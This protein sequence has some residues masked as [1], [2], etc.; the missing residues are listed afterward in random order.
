VKGARTATASVLIAPRRVETVSR[1][2]P[3]AGPRDVV[4][5][6]EGCGVC[7]S[8]LPLWEG[9]PW[10]R[11]PQAPGAPGHEAWGRVFAVGEEVRRVAPGQRVAL[12]SLNGFAAFDTSR[13]D[14]C[15]ALP[16]ELDGLPF[17]GEALG[18]AVNVVRR[19]RVEAGR[20]VAIVGM[21]FLGTAIA[22]L[23]RHLGAEVVPVT[24]NGGLPEGP[25]ACVIE[26]AGTQESLDAA[27]ALVAE[28][29]VLVIAGYHQDG[30][31]QVDVQSWNWR[32]L[33]VVNAHERLLSRQVEGLSE[34]ARLAVE[35]AFDLERLCTHV[36]DPGQLGEAFEAARRRPAGFTKALVRQ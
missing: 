8:S 23:C 18:C 12:L 21:G 14:A 10:F 9:R 13:E 2:V 16:A 34:A 35:G 4:V 24:R 25:F 6:I 19:A 33:D 28:G 30:P 27:S 29:G 31:R 7:A 5:R 11:Y 26:A 32:G 17:P 1:P 22:G 20:A 36:F 15:V 3:D